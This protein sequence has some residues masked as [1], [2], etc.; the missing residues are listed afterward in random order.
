MK[1]HTVKVF[2]GIAVS[3]VGEQWLFGLAKGIGGVGHIRSITA[4]ATDTNPFVVLQFPTRTTKATILHATDEW[5][6]RV[7][8]SRDTAPVGLNAGD[9]NTRIQNAMAVSSASRDGGGMRKV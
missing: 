3:P 1:T 9:L 6:E 4:F 7:E 5:T 2:T 8:A